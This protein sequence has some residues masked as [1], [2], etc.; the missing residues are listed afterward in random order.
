[1]TSSTLQWDMEEGQDN[2]Q[3]ST[4][5]QNPEKN[6]DHKIYTQGQK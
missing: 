2:R 5:R 6:K 1:M 4:A 3:S